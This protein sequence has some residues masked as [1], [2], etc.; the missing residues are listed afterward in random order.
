MAVYMVN[1][2]KYHGITKVG[3]AD[4][5]HKRLFELERHH[6]KVVNVCY[7]DCESSRESLMW[8]D[9]IHKSFLINEIYDKKDIFLSDY[10]HKVCKMGESEFFMMDS[11]L[12]RLSWV[13]EM[14]KPFNH[15]LKYLK[16]GAKGH[17]ECSEEDYLLENLLHNARWAFHT[18]WKGNEE[19]KGYQEDILLFK[20]LLSDT[21]KKEWLVEELVR[22]KTSQNKFLEDI[23][24][25]RRF[26]PDSKT[27]GE[28]RS[29]LSLYKS[30]ESTLQHLKDFSVETY[31][32]I[33]NNLISADDKKLDVDL[34]KAFIRRKS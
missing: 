10:P 24:M 17:T 26:F 19:E 5:I 13:Q 28:A 30:T 29:Y 16:N 7:F 27:T 18:F 25:T 15:H 22:V 4:D 3:K 2:E 31:V 32:D 9:K 11:V 21:G 14:L 23:E 20:R 1:F 6:G 8:E 33:R 12:S 34:L